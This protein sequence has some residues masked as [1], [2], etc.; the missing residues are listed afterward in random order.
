MER[1]VMNVASEA[2]NL[3]R[4]GDPHGAALI[5]YR[6]SREVK[7]HAKKVAKPI[8]KPQKPDRICYDCGKVIVDG[9]DRER[10]KRKGQWVD[11]HRYDCELD[12]RDKLE[13]WAFD[14]GLIWGRND[15]GKTL[16]QVKDEAIREF[17]EKANDRT[18]EGMAFRTEHV[19]KGQS[20][21][22]TDK[23]GN[24]LIRGEQ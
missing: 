20:V 17:Y 18:E 7:D 2:V 6:L 13:R 22:L 8:P 11:V 5:L 12:T 10:R 19:Y 15:E 4:N 24:P 1:K 14:Q 16:K 21:A 3:L 23:D 9:V